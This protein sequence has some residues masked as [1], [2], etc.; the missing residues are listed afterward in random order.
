M[1][2]WFQVATWRFYDV[3]TTTLHQSTYPKLNLKTLLV[4]KCWMLVYSGTLLDSGVDG[5][6]VRMDS[7]TTVKSEPCGHGCGLFH[8]ASIEQIAKMSRG[9]VN[10]AF[11]KLTV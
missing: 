10:I 11:N 4:M 9:F 7:S 6:I 8:D 5:F 1:D 2:D 3:A